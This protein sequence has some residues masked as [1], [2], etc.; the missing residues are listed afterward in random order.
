MNEWPFGAI[1]MPSSSF[2][3]EVICSGCP[4]GKCCRQIWKVPPALEFRYIHFPSGDHAAAVH[5]AL[6]APTCQPAELP[7][8]GTSRQ[9]GH[10]AP[11]ACSTTSAHL[12]SG[13]GYRRSPTLVLGTSKDGK[14]ESE[15][16]A[17]LR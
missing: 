14:L 13:N 2:G 1:A 16:R 12:L 4:S 7:S 6:A 8:V 5:P 15:K 11:G 3:P 17:F 10:T 9:G